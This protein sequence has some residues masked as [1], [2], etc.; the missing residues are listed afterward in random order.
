MQLLCAA[1]SGNRSQNPTIGASIG[2]V[3][4]PKASRRAGAQI[5]GAD[6]EVNRANKRRLPMR[7]CV[8]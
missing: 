3:V 7:F 5:K 8:N 2:V 1:P 4:K 6:M